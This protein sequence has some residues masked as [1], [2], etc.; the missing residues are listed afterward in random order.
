MEVQLT[1]IGLWDEERGV[2]KIRSQCVPFV[3]Q[4]LMNPTRIHEY[5]SMRV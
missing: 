5:G 2:V 3:V 1:E 4:W